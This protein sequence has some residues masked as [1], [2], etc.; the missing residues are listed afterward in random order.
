MM[1]ATQSHSWLA[2]EIA[3]GRKTTHL[4]LSIVTTLYNSAQTVEDFYHRMVSAAEK[5]TASF[6][7]VI[8]DDGSPDHS[9][10][11]A[12]RLAERDARVKVVELSRNFGHHRALMTG[13]MHSSGDC[14]FMIDSDL[15]ED[16]ALLAAFWEKLHGADL[17]VVYG[18]QDIR[19]GSAFRR[20]TGALAYKLFDW[21]IPYK[22]PANHIT[23]R[24]MRRAYVN[25]LL[26][27]REQQTAIGGLWVITGYHQLGIPVAK[28][29]RKVTT[30]SFAR[31]WHVLIN[32]V[33]S[34]SETPLIAIFYLGIFISMISGIY[35]TALIIRWLLDGS[36]VPGWLSVMVSVWLLGGLAIFCMGLIGIYLS[37]IFIETKN[38]PYSIVRRIHCAKSEDGRATED[39]E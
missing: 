12:C 24:L 11:I 26:L 39:L 9:L 2:P 13:L 29:V 34:F 4:A 14:C 37:K 35:A 19:A 6:E 18:Y 32:S 5:I 16:P 27:H 30:Y 25:S 31:R 28:T 7:I 23:V 22:I 38:R 3:T 17:D 21:L 10:E 20:A 1:T 36:S 33:T 8:V 15:E